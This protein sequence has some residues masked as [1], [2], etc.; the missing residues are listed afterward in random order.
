MQIS[1]IFYSIQGEGVNIG[2]PAIFI[3]LNLC[4]LRCVWCD[5]KYTWRKE[6][7][8]EM[9]IEKIIKEI[10]KYPAKHLVITGGEPLIQQKELINLLKKLGD[11]FIEIETNGTIQPLEELTK[12]IN[13]YNC[14]PK[15]KNAK[16]KNRELKKFPAEK[17]Y[18][19][20][21][22]ERKKDI[23]EI[24]KIMKTLDKEKIIL[25]PQGTTKKNLAKTSKL[26]AEICKKENLRFTPRLHMEIWGNKR[27]K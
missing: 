7:G 8:K 15:L 3:R 18:Y 20:F 10:K 11:Y 1:E 14:S 26:L 16:T 25:M 22:V 17:T 6:F 12:L 23:D 27:K 19:K 13:Q 9:T 2:K 4:D 24:K 5:S 21:V